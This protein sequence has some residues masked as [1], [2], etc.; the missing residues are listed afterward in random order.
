M[1]DQTQ[2]HQRLQYLSCELPI[3]QRPDKDIYL[4]QQDYHGII[5]NLRYQLVRLGGVASC[6]NS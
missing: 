6:I 5:G 3:D 2:Q 4:D 1:Y